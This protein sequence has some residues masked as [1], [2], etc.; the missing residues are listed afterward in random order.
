MNPWLILGVAAAWLISCAGVGYWQNDAG[1]TAERVT[2]Q[3]RENKELTVKNAKIL[4]LT[5]RVRKLEAKS[6]DDV[7]AAATQLKKEKDRADKAEKGALAAATAGTAFR[8]RWTASCQGSSG[9]AGPAPGTDPGGGSGTAT[10][11]LPAATRDDLIRLAG[12]ADK[13]VAERNALLVIAQKDREVC[14]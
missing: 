12:D 5:N 8:L 11:E 13:V 9:S 7:A 2:W 1:H 3:E 14:Q 10:C 6:A 4:E